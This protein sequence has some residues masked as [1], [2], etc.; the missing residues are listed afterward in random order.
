MKRPQRIYHFRGGV[1]KGA[2]YKWR[3]GYSETWA[4]G[5]IVYPWMTR[6][7]CRA[8]AKRSGYQAVFMRDGRR[9]VFG[10]RKTQ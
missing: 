7:E 6:A 10:R 9:E 1:E 8:H 4:D 5:G 3:E 2:D